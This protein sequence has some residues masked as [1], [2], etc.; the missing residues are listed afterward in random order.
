MIQESLDM[1]YGQQENKKN[2]TFVCYQNIEGLSSIGIQ[3]GDQQ[4][5]EECKCA[6]V[7][8]VD[9][10]N[11]NIFTLQLVLENTYNVKS[12]V[13]SMHFISELTLGF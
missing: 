9:D 12:V 11:F 7:L 8:I 4:I 3:K 6:K 1:N 13:V 2:N 10:N 5:R